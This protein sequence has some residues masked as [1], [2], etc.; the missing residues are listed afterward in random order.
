MGGELR[1][2]EY[3]RLVTTAGSIRSVIAR[4]SG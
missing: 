2:P 4:A 1:A 3:D